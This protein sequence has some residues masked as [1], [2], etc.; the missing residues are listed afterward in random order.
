[1]RTVAAFDIDG[2]LAR[3]DTVL[4]FLARVAG[5][6]ALVAALASE[7]RA[8]ARIGAGGDA[9]DAAKA[10]VVSR[11]L[12]GRPYDVVRATGES[13]AA[14][15][16]AVRLRPDVLGRLRWHQG[17]GDEVVLV[18][19]ALDV[20]VEPL[21]RELGAEVLATRLAVGAAGE[22]TGELDGANCRGDEKLRRLR[23][24]VG[25]DV[26]L[27]AYGNS[28]GDAPMLDA[29]D[30]GVWVGRRAISASA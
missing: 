14:E 29:A 18:T 3:R 11:M 15:L 28:S 19:A 17:R 27:W 7:W 13:Y 16:R 20:Y 30:V 1:M 8:L 26:E 22:L 10:A 23:L 6:P 4:P 5:R 2:T 24:L 9:R 25:D 21:G 12:G